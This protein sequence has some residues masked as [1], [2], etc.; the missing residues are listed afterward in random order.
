MT[1]HLLLATVPRRKVFVER[2]LAAISE[3]TVVPSV[4]HLCLE[5]Y[6]DVIAPKYPES[7][8]VKEYRTQQT[9]GPGAR[10]RIISE[11]S[12]DV[13]KLVVLDDDWS[14]SSND[15]IEKLVSAAGTD[16]A[17]SYIGLSVSRYLTEEL[18]V[19][20]ISMGG[21]AMALPVQHLAG[22]EDLRQEIIKACS[23]DPFGNLGD[24]EA[25]VAAHLWRKGVKMF[26][27]GKLG[28]WMPPQA[29]VDC[30]GDRRRSALRGKKFFWQREA[31]A[32]VTG[33]PW[34]SR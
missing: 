24:D 33:W 22:L 15:V 27:A 29:Q 16:S 3:Q 32:K 17:S 28:L 2:I 11:I 5:G 30:Q 25:V 10:W 1:I 31:I 9:T 21:A 14:M 13:D 18:G 23:F 19:E 12:S 20:L 7:L 34:V 4:V 26:A 8:S 6:G